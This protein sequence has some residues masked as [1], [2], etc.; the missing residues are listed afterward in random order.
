MCRAYRHSQVA[1]QE[2]AAVLPHGCNH[3]RPDGE[4]GGKGTCTGCHT[5]MMHTHTAHPI[6]IEGIDQH[7]K[8]VKP[9]AHQVDCCSEDGV[10]Y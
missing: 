3:W 6:T 10:Q 8:L 9:S 1:V 5:Q 7:T 2:H 4:V